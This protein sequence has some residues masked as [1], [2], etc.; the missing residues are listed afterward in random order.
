MSAVDGEHRSSV[1]AMHFSWK[2]Y[3]YPNPCDERILTDILGFVPE[4]GQGA[5]T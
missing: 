5:L 1:S 3:G 2:S 4:A